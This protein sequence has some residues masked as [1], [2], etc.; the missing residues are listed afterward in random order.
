MAARVSAVGTETP[1]RTFIEVVEDR[2]NPDAEERAF[3][4]LP[5]WKNFL[6]KE[7]TS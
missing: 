5:R 3:F 6:N 7:A 4:F 1:P 2:E